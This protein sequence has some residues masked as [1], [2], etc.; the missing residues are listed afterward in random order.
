MCFFF[1]FFWKIPTPE[2]EDTQPIR[3]LYIYIALAVAI[4]T[5]FPELKSNYWTLYFF[6][7]NRCIKIAIVHDI[8]E[9][10]WNLNTFLFFL[11][12]NTTLS[13]Y[14]K[15]CVHSV[16]WFPT[17]PFEFFAFTKHNFL[18]IFIVLLMLCLLKF[19]LTGRMKNKM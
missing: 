6:Y 3:R 5:C 8:A 19:W 15:S 14:D 13:A 11:F 18:K 7:W 1:F 2:I 10:I 16:I 17:M 9:G 12:L 4:I